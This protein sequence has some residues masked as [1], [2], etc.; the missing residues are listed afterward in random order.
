MATISASSWVLLAVAALLP[1]ACSGSLVVV[2]SGVEVARGRTVFVTEKELKISV[3][4]TADCKVE[5]V[6]NEPVTQ[7]VGKV[8]P[9]VFDCHFLEDE[10]KYV[11]NGSPLLDEDT[12]MLR[13][14]RFTAS[15][16]LMETVVMQVRVVDSRPSLVELGITPLVVPQFYGLSNAI[17]GSVLSIRTR[18]DLV[19]TVRLMTS[20]TSTPSLGQLVTEEDSGQRKGRETAVLCPGNKPCLHSTKEVRFL[21]ASCQEFLSS[22]L[23]YQHL[24]PPSPEIDYIP[25]RVELREQ[26][27]RALLETEGVWLPVLIHGAMQNQPPQA[28]FMASFILEVD[29]F[30]LT[31]LTTAALDAKDHESPQERLIFNVTT[32]PAEGYITL[33]DD[34]TKPSRS[35]TWLDLHEM[36]VAYQPPNSSHSHRRNYEVEFQAIDGSYMTS[37]PIVVHISIRAAETN[38]P[39]VSWNMGLDLLEGQSRPITWEELQ[40]VDNDN[41]DAVYLVAVDGPLHGRLSVRGGKAFMFRVQD[42][43]SGVV[44]YHH[45]DSDTTRDHIVFRISDGRH[46]I[47]HKFPINI[48]PKDDT[49]PFLINNVA[50]E[51][52]EGGA[53]RLEEYMLLASDLDSSDDYILYQLVSSPR[54]GQ[55]VKKNSPQ[56]PGAAVESFLQRDLSQGLIYYQHSGDECFEDSFDFTL[57]DGHQPP[58]LSHRHTVVVQVFPVKDQ[59]PVEVSGSVRSLTVEES[60]LVHLTPAHLHFTDREHPDTDLSYVITQPCFSPV[61]PG[62]MDAGR[63]FYTDSTNAMKKD[64]MVPVLKSFTQHAV[65]HMKVAFMPPIE[66]IGPEPLFVQFV[67]SVS[68]HHG[69]TV[70]GLLFNITVT[71]VDNQT[72]EVFSN[73]LRV[74]EGGAAFVVEEHLLVRDRDS[75]EEALRVEVQR[76][77]LHGR[78][79]LQGRKLHQGDSFTLQDLRGFRLRYIHDDSETTEDTVGLTVT[80]GH[81]SAHVVLPIQVLL[82]NDE[83]P[84]LGRDLRGELSC[85]EGG[86]VQVT[87]DYLSA[88][89]QD[90]DDSRLTYMLARS[91]SR[92]EL[93]RSGLTVDKFS[94]HDLLQGTIYYIHTGGEIGPDP[95]SDTVTLIVSDGE[96]GVTDSCCHGDAP[97]PP[98]PLHGTLPVYDLNVTVLPVNNKVP[99]V[100]LGASMFVV[101][102]GSSACLCGGVLGASDPDTHPDQLTFHLEAPPQHGFLENTLPTPGY[103]KSNAGLRVES[104]S[105]IHLTSGYINYVQSEHR[106]VEPTVDQLSISVSDGLHHSAPVPFYIIIS[107]TNDETP[108]LLLANFTVKEGGMRDLGPALL[109]GFDLDAPA[110]VLTFTMVEPPAHGSLL[111][112]IYG[113]DMSRYKEM[114]ADLLHRSLPVHSFTLQELR[115]GMKIVYM[116]DDTETL[117]D[118]VA[119]QLT[120]G[121]HTVQGTAQVTVLPANDEKPRLLKNAGLEVDSLERR[122]ISSVVLEAEDLDTPPNHVY[123]IL[124]AGPRFGKLQLKAASGWTEL[125]AGQNF[126]QEDVEMNRLWYAHTAG[127]AAGFKG[128][129]SFRFYLSDLD[130]ESPAQSFFISVRTVQKGDIVLRSKA[131]KLMEGERVVLTTDILLATDSA[132]RPA[133]LLY[134]VS[135]PPRHGH[136]H[137]VQRPGLPLLSF[138]QL[139]VAAHRVCYTHDNSHTAETDSFS[140]V[141]TNG[142]TSRS[143]TLHFTIEHGDRI[144][145]SISRN[146]GLKLQDGAVATITT[147]QLQLTDPDTATA[148][149]TYI[150]TQLP[151]YGKLLLKGLPLSPL[152]FTQTD[153]DN[154]NLAY[155]H[156]LGSPAEIDR[157]YF[158]PSDGNN[159]GYLEYG[160]LREE[161]IVFNIQ[162]DRVDRTPPSLATRRSPSTVV[163]LEGGRYGIFITSRHLQASDPDSPTQE[164]EFTIT[165]P[166]HFG[167]LENIL[168]GA[169]I[170]GRFTQRDVDQR[171]VVFVVPADMEVTGDSFQF[172]L[173]DPAGNTML[174]EILDL[175]WSRVELSASCYRVCETAGTLQ[176]QIQRSGKSMDPAYVAIQVVEGSAKPGRDFTHSTASLIQFDPGVSLKTWNI[177]LTDDGLEEN[178]ETFSVTLKN[179]NNAVLGQRDSASVE[180]IDPRGGRCDPEDLRVEEDEA[181]APPPAPRPSQPPRPEEEEDLVTDI[182]AELLWENQP[183]PPRGDVPHRRPYLDYGEGEPQDQAAPSYSYTHYPTGQ[184][185][186][187]GT[188]STGRTG[189]GIR[190]AG[191]VTR[192]HL[193]GER[194]TEEK[195]W[196]FHSL[197]PLRLEEVQQGAAGWS[198]LQELRL[199]DTPQMDNPPKRHPAPKPH[200][201]LRQSKTGKSISSS[202]PDGWTHYRRRCFLLGPGVASWGSAQRS[203]SLLFGSSLTSVRSKRGVAWLWRFA[204]K[205]PFWIGL[206]GG[207]GRWAWADGSAVSSSSLKGAPLDWSGDDGDDCVL[208]ESPRSWTSA[209]C[210]T[211]IEHAFICS[212]PAHTQHTHDCVATQSSNTIVKFADDTA[213]VGLISNGDETAYRKEV[214]ALE[215]WC[216][217]N[218]LSLNVSK[219]KEVIVDYGDP[220]PSLHQQHSGG[221]GGQLQVPGSQHPPGPDVGQP[222]HHCRQKGPTAPTRTQAPKEIWPKAPNPRGFYR[223]TIESLLTGCFTSWYGNCTTMDRKALRR[224]RRAAQ[225]VTGCELPKLQELYT[226][227]CLRKSQ[228]IIKDTTHRHNSLF[229][230]QPSGR[231]YRVLKARTNRLRNSFFPQATRLLNK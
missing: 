173:T 91:P 56:E 190:P 197:T 88:T 51:V 111:N 130:N 3:D 68:D 86:G 156:T 194:R 20:D 14:Y 70:A 42:L 69:G 205:K 121:V 187:L 202:C 229:S 167:Y 219:T 193:S 81:N 213:V 21:K 55:L 10:V 192:V 11:H 22:G 220:P 124:N 149:L 218:H 199:G 223:G 200:P 176:I 222:H 158:L 209:G 204:G 139:D 172:R 198:L 212:A 206:S 215:Q 24:S 48:L 227:R 90:S 23:K 62:I 12:V 179:P 181:R 61:Y 171:A 144:P 41:I 15:E 115:Q 169:Y 170:K 99:S 186:P 50:V 40:I 228:R 128:H 84:Q 225:H 67:F 180:I 97:P 9:Q 4:P 92:G 196:T 164:L 13:V 34:H 95:V 153:V 47:R 224:V 1:F 33:L 138:T 132:G 16:T 210:S 63:L 140:F 25:I 178:H 107:P 125:S 163:E 185:P 183:H 126:T 60:Q 122:V 142:D 44:V 174:P 161:P 166:P 214:E 109:N 207:P 137:A 96:A 35:F 117:K 105:L 150:V 54:A 75:R 162:V 6:L 136:V 226:Q 131:V 221:E 155:Q 120:D 28:A 19:C 110:D 104:F 39:R 72:P 38:A 79:E 82:V 175:S 168:T 231:R 147:D 8:S 37:P 119:V 43:R 189:H 52:Q 159:R 46:S 83:P 154:L 211:D 66:D 93:Q 177:Y 65:N 53:V 195:V 58:N 17:D 101:D 85:E 203:C 146:A 143:G 108:S 89:D 182:E 64:P 184:L 135:V 36:K 152:T 118:T 5:V 201:K 113:T 141:I 102:E 31:P 49:P 127:A 123:Y 157:F 191:P 80:D 2:N 145:P 59:L 94:Q 208:V 114:G 32:P 78:L 216:Q 129:D 148:N 76:E 57:S 188:G 27:S 98:V 151:R 100:T 230:L 30:I 77:A 45:S 26:A 217:D 29:Q 160:Q 106:G 73:L 71:P 7:R 133:E 74:E 165:R 18:P 87:V 134:A 103:E 116:H 112:G